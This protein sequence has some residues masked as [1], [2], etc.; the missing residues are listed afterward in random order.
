MT[1]PPRVL[2]ILTSSQLVSAWVQYV[3]PMS[4]STGS[5]PVL[6]FD[7]LQYVI[8]TNYM[9]HETDVDIYIYKY[10]IYNTYI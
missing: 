4:S 7:M 1:M 2:F 10:V 3:Y 9:P 5:T 6:Y 8:Y